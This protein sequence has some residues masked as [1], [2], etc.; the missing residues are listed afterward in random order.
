MVFVPMAQGP[1][2]SRVFSKIGQRQVLRID[3]LP[4]LNKPLPILPKNRRTIIRD[5]QIETASNHMHYRNFWNVQR[6]KEH[7]GEY[8]L[9]GKPGLWNS[10][11][12]L[13]LTCL[14]QCHRVRFHGKSSSQ[15]WRKRIVIQQSEFSP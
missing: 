15:S 8:G 3:C 7:P 13:N 12:G 9:S 5:V 14:D 1:P 2:K 4:I 11:D 10:H 6:A